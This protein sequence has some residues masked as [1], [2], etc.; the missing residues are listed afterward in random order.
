[1]GNQIPNKTYRLKFSNSTGSP[2]SI[3]LKPR[4]FCEVRPNPIAAVR[5]KIKNWLVRTRIFRCTYAR[6]EGIEFDWTY[7]KLLIPK[8]IYVYY[9][10]FLLITYYSNI[11]FQNSN[12]PNFV[13]WLSA[14]LVFLEKCQPAEKTPR[15]PASADNPTKCV[16]HNVRNASN[17]RSYAG[18]NCRL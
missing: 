3:N 5:C 16:R 7:L 8:H 15:L 13:F 17:V 10:Y 12:F 18:A 4:Q 11:E 6:F 1:M 2:S 9:I 14:R